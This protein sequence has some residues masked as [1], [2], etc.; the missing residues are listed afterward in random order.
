MGKYFTAIG[1][2]D[3]YFEMEILVD[4]S[5]ETKEQAKEIANDGN[6]NIGMLHED[7]LVVKGSE[8]VIRKEETNK[9]QFRICKE[10]KVIVSEEDYTEVS[11]DEAI[12]YL[13]EK[14]N[15]ELP[16]SLESYY[17]SVTEENP[18]EKEVVESK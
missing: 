11:W 18:F 5:A 1:L 12:E 10:D 3:G 14:E 7:M 2:H 17:Y 13:T 15:R 4:T 16:L 8:L 9:Y 6:F